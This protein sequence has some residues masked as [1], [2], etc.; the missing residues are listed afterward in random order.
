MSPDRY[1]NESV[2]ERLASRPFHHHWLFP[3]GATVRQAIAWPLERSVSADGEG[4][5]S[6]IGRIPITVL[7]ET[8][9][10]SL[11][12]YRNE[13]FASFPD[14]EVRQLVAAWRQGEEMLGW[15]QLAWDQFY[16]PV[17]VTQW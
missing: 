3:V 5:N 6:P 10:G 15:E 13:R 17:S 9:S 14:S 2:C 12:A 1:F 7:I 11:L 8:D 4:T 16:G